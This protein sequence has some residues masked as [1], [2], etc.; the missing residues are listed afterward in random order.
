MADK[1]Q[2]TQNLIKLAAF[3]RIIDLPVV[4]TEQQKL[5]PTMPEIMEPLEGSQAVNKITFD[6]FACSD[7]N[8][9]IVDLDKPTLILCGIESHICVLQTA[10]MGLKTHRVQV[11]TDAV[12]SRSK[13]NWEIALRRMEKA[14]CELTTT[15]MVMYELLR[16]AGTDEF[17]E[18]LPLVK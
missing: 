8:Q 7:F 1:E 14:G 12:S 11:V 17:R 10:L 6:C 16:R 15:E 18:V 4:I 3:S 13:H 2:C 9:A 5:G